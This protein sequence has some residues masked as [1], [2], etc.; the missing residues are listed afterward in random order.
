MMTQSSIISRREAA[1]TFR[2]AQS[3]PPHVPYVVTIYDGQL[4]LWSKAVAS[5]GRWPLDSGLRW[6]ICSLVLQ[7]AL[8]QLQLIGQQQ[9][10]GVLQGNGN[11]Q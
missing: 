10:I 6:K 7:A 11:L 1:T 3:L 2:G 4:N 9:N 5:S 8:I